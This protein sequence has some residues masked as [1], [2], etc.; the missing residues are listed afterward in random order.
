MKLI[1]NEHASFL[2][3]CESEEAN[4][5]SLVQAFDPKSSNMTDVQG[6]LKDMELADFDALDPE[7]REDLM[8]WERTSCDETNYASE[9]KSTL[10][11]MK[12]E[13]YD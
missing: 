6:S 11:H 13:V 3:L 8:S 7:E 12:L 1:N 9:L 5:K 10:S 4:I 2:D